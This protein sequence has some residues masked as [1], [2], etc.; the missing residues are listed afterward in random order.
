V[1][2]GG[3][4]AVLAFWKGRAAVQQVIDFTT[5]GKHLTVTRPDASGVIPDD[6]DV[7][8]AGA[9]LVAGYD[10]PT[11]V[12]SLAR[13]ARSE[14]VDGKELRMHVAF[15]DLAELKK[16]HPATFQTITDLMTYSTLGEPA[17]GH[18]GD[19]I[20]RRYATTRDP[21]ENDARLALQV[22]RDRQAGIDKAAGA[23]KFVDKSAFGKQPGTR[24]YADVLAEWTGDGLVPFNLPSATSGFVLF[25][26]A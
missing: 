24:T 20:G 25:R 7:L 12:Y 16:S 8:A 11:D 22:F 13:M 10:M 2:G 15:N 9:S 26:R 3:L 19:Q 1:I 23:I 18:Y 5:K 21:Y 14:G 4:V 17:Q 6:P